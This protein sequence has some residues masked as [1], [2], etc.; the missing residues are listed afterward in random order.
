MES[1]TIKIDKNVLRK[2]NKSMLERGYS[3]KTEFIREAIR[4]KIDKNEQNRLIKEF[5]KLKGKV[6]NT[7]LD[8]ERK[9]IRDEVADEFAKEFEI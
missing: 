4:D 9:K 5:M 1:I 3:T 7:T 6:K 2:M 8:K